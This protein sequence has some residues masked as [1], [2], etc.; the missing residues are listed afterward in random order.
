MNIEADFEQLDIGEEPIYERNV[1]KQTTMNIKGKMSY[2]KQGLP[3]KNPPP[4]KLEMSPSKN[5]DRRPVRAKSSVQKFDRAMID[6][7]ESLVK[8]EVN[9]FMPTSNPPTI[10]GDKQA[11]RDSVSTGNGIGTIGRFSNTV[12]FNTESLQQFVPLSKKE[13]E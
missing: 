11:N 1:I 3:S 9:G 7:E 12:D 10:V 8:Q 4:R 2:L 13:H 6:N 5:S